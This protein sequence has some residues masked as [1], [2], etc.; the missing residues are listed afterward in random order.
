MKFR[1][2]FPA[3]LT[4]A[5]LLLTGCL[6]QAR[7]QKNSFALDARPPERQIDAAGR[8]TLLVGTVSVAPGLDNRALVY[9]V[10]P[11]QFETDFYNEFMAPPARL[12]ADQISRY[13]DAANRRLRVVKSAG[14]VLADFGLETHLETMHG[15]FTVEPPQAVVS[16]RFT[17]N[18]LRRTPTGVLLDKTYRREVPMAAK[19]PAAMVAALN[20]GLRDILSEFNG[21]VERRLR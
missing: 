3:L 19:T 17:L 18:D 8:R 6:T 10:G 21:D 2:I 5:A 14:L 13:L 20:E 7:P 9:R 12:L 1:W 16:L 15:D 11:S 4:A